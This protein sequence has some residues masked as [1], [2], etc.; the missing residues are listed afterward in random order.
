MVCKSQLRQIG[1]HFAA[2]SADHGNLLPMQVSV[3]NGGSMDF[4]TGGSAVAHFLPLTN[5][6][7]PWIESIYMTESGSNRMVV[8]TNYGLNSA[9]LSCPS[10]TASRRNTTFTRGFADTNISYFVGLD[11]SLEKPNSILSGDRHLQ[12]EKQPVKPGLLELKPSSRISWSRELHSPLDN[13]NILFADGHAA[14]T[15]K[16][17]VAIA[18]QNLPTNRLAIP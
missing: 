4:I 7:S 11:A 3:A 6:G 2:W 8:R 17:A 9:R 12:V 1:V 5:S 15:K 16:W 14:L 13:G 10:E 18:N